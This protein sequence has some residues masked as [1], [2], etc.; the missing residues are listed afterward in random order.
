[1]AVKKCPTDAGAWYNLGVGYEYNYMFKEAIEALKKA[2]KL[3]P[4]DA[5]IREISN[6]KHLQAE[7]AKLKQQGAIQEGM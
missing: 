3:D 2:N 7:R 4:S 6:V 1:M 5:C